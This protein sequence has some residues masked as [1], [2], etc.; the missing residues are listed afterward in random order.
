MFSSLL[1]KIKPRRAKVEGISGCIWDVLCDFGSFSRVRLNLSS[2]SARWKMWRRDTG[3]GV[4]GSVE[5][6]GSGKHGADVKHGVLVENVGCKWQTRGTFFFSAKIW[7]F[8]PKMRSRHF[9]SL[10][11]SENQFSI[12][13]WN[14]FHD[15]KSKLRLQYT[16]RGVS[17]ASDVARAV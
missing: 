16:F 14:A 2:F 11:C 13:R 15:Q 4:P 1:V 3:Y 6:T 7:I 12:S 8:L 10:N 5:N 9:V 17:R